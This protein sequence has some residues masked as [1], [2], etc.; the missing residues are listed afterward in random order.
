METRFR[1]VLQVAVAAL[2]L[3]GSGLASA[4]GIAGEVIGRSREAQRSEQPR[5]ESRPAPR[6]ESRPAPRTAEPGRGEAPRQDPRRA[7]VRP[8]VPRSAG[9]SPVEPP[10]ANAVGP[11]RPA[12]SDASSAHSSNDRGRGL[13]G[14]L[15]QR[16]YQTRDPRPDRGDRDHDRGDSRWRDLR[17]HHRDH[18][19][20]VHVIHHLPP[21]YRDYWW[22]GVRYYYYDGF[23]YRP[24]GS[25]YISVRVP[26]GFFVTSLP[27]R[28]TSVWIGGTRYYYSDHHYYVY[29]PGRR[30]YVVVPSPYGDDDEADGDLYIYPAQGQSEQQQAEDRYQ[31]HRWAVDQSG[32]DPLDDDY[33]ADQREQYL[34]AMTA[35]LEG[36]G[37]TVR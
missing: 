1:R 3:A 11:V 33:D 22:N 19:H 24:Y 30:G 31:C 26:Y 27:G 28:F 34:R 16:E 35:C 15:I 37:Y 5:R 23:W 17:D 2:A 10:R 7:E 14:S 13:A 36:R 8:A 18:H 29:E 20:H 25:S 32:Y 9:N 4:E 21:G 12:Q 6:N